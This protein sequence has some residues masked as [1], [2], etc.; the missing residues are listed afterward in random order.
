LFPLILNYLVVV[1]FLGNRGS[2]NLS[3]KVDGQGPVLYL[4]DLLLR[5]RGDGLGGEVLIFFWVVADQ[6]DFDYFR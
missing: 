4:L 1:L 6:V 5:G 3:L 2:F